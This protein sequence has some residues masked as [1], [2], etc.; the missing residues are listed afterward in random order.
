MGWVGRGGES[1]FG[2]KF[3]VESAEEEVL[4]VER[5]TSRTLRFF[6]NA[7]WGDE[8]GDETKSETVPASVGPDTGYRR[9]GNLE[10]PVSDVEHEDLSPVRVGTHRLRQLTLSSEVGSVAEA[11]GVVRVVL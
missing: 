5:E 3:R 4:R 11:L 7:G 10:T 8:G 9:V 2:M 6:S 1:D